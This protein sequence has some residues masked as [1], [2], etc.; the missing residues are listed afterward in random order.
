MEITPT[1]RRSTSKLGRNTS[2]VLP[3]AVWINF[4]DL[5]EATQNKL[6]EKHKPKLAFPALLFGD[7]QTGWPRN[8][9]TP[10]GS[11]RKIS[12]HQQ[13][14]S[15]GHRAACFHESSTRMARQLHQQEAFGRHVAVLHRRRSRS[16]PGGLEQDCAALDRVR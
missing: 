13:T 14:G 8:P 2:P 1:C 12:L 10:P 7:D 4:G 16:E 15:D 3:E 11:R 6:W 5:P 9:L